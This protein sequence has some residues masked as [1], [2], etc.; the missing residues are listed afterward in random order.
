[1]LASRSLPRIS[2]FLLPLAQAA[3]I[4]VYP[5][6][7]AVEAAAYTFG[8]TTT[9]IKRLYTNSSATGKAHAL[10]EL[11]NSLV[12]RHQ[13]LVDHILP[14]LRNAGRLEGCLRTADAATKQLHVYGSKKDEI[15]GR[16]RDASISE[17]YSKTFLVDSI[18]ELMERLVKLNKETTE[19]STRANEI[20]A[21]LGDAIF[22][23]GGLVVKDNNGNEMNYR[24]SPSD[25]SAVDSSTVSNPQSNDQDLVVSTSSVVFVR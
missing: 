14:D 1:M 17:N 8:V 10:E 3:L 4:M 24:A 15:L 13:H 22:S 19:R 7:M 12:Q 18:D 25:N 21:E 11:H 6:N 2:S 5:I 23:P 16:L 9:L 20:L